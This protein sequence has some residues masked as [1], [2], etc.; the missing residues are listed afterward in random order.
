MFICIERENKERSIVS[1]NSC[2]VKKNITGSMVTIEGPEKSS[3]YFATCETI[4]LVKSEEIAFRFLNRDK[5]LLEAVHLTIIGDVSKLEG[6]DS[7][8]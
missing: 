6:I 1:L 2:K 8:E 7:G 3:S 4:F 5:I